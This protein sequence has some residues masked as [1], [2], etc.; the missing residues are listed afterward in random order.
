MKRKRVDKLPPRYKFLLNPC[1]DV[2]LSKCPCCDRLTHPRRFALFI[3]VREF[4]T[5][6][7][8]KPAAIAR[9]ASL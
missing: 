8:G 3:H 4:G 6:V 2:R 5:I 1:S 9:P 7:W